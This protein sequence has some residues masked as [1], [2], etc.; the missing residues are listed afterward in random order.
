VNPDQG[1]KEKPK[2]K[3]FHVL[4]ITKGESIMK[5]KNWKSQENGQKMVSL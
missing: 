3:C 4:Y 1:E 2:K 5:K